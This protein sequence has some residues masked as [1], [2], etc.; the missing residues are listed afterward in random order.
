MAKQKSEIPTRAA[1]AVA[2]LKELNPALD[3]WTAQEHLAFLRYL[4][5]DAYREL[6]AWRK[7]VE[8]KPGATPFKDDTAAFN[9]LLRDAVFTHPTYSEQANFKKQLIG[10]G[11]LEAGSNEK[12]MYD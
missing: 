4:V 3:N 8:A 2:K 6:P 5:M 9:A 11:E 10:W 7:A 12:P 1:S